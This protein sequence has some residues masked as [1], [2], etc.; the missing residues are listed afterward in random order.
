MHYLAQFF[1]VSL[2]FASG[3]AAQATNPGPSNVYRVEVRLPEG[4]LASGEEMHIELRITDSR[5]EDPLMGHAPVVRARVEGV[6]DMPSMASMPGI[7][8]IAHPEGIPGEYGLHP[9]FPHGGTYRMRLTVTTVKGETFGFESPLE[10]GEARPA[11][12]KAK[13]RYRLEMSG[14]AESLRLRVMGPEGPV[15]AFDIAHERALHFIAIRKDFQ[16]FQHLHPE[17]EANGTFRLNHQWPAGGD[18]LVFADTAPKGKGS[19]ILSGRL[20][21]KGGTGATPEAS[22]LAVQVD[23]IPA[24]GRTGELKLTLSPALKLEP[25]LGAMA[26][27]LMIAEGSGTLVHAHPSEDDASR[28]LVR[29]PEPGRY[30]AWVEVQTGGKVIATPFAVEVR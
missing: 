28:F 15:T 19:Q 27:L 24:A 17:M 6:V 18:Y 20:K 29:F 22:P 4:G 3:L 11:A 5:V 21:V 26:H 9:V 10:V 16:V 13:P 1:I 14:P 8:G 12:A 30:R 23:A 25:Y 2:A 7:S